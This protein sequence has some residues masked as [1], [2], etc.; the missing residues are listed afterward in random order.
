MKNGK[1]RKERRVA[2]PQQKSVE[3]THEVGSLFF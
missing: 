2:F 3:P 1:V